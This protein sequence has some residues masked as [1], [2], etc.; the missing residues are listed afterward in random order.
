MK[1]KAE[2]KEKKKGPFVYF[3]GPNLLLAF[4][5]L[6]VVAVLSLLANAY[7]ISSKT[8]SGGCDIVMVGYKEQGAAGMLEIEF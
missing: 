3:N 1:N 7:V 5:L 8:H 4:L 2:R 6:A